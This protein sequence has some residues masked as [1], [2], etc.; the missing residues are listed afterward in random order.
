MALVSKSAEVDTV[1]LYGSCDLH[2]WSFRCMHA[3]PSSR[4]FQDVY[5][6]SE[7]EDLHF[8]AQ[9][10]NKGWGDQAIWLKTG[11]PY[12]DWT[13]NTDLLPSTPAQFFLQR[14]LIQV[15]YFGITIDSQEVR[16]HLRRGS[17]VLHPISPLITSC[18]TLLQYCNQEF[19]TGRIHRAYS[20]VISIKLVCVH[21]HVY[22]FRNFVTC[23]FIQPPPQSR[24][25]TIS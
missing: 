20:D 15:F 4:R 22:S 6:N 9:K 14:A 5:S 7:R 10:R 24:S 25:R 2:S 21:V 19:D 3:I 13:Q 8:A 12:W 17:V 23:R 18:I 1:L 11:K 16:K